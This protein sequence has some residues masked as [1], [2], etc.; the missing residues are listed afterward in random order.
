MTLAILP[1]CLIRL[2][3]HNGFAN[4][5]SFLTHRQA[6]LKGQHDPG[7]IA[8]AVEGLDRKSIPT[9]NGSK[10]ASVAARASRRHPRLILLQTDAEKRIALVR[11]YTSGPPRRAR[12]HSTRRSAAPRSSSA[13]TKPA[14]QNAPMPHKPATKQHAKLRGQYL[15][16]GTSIFVISLSMYLN[17]CAK[18]VCKDVLLTAIVC[19]K[20][21][22]LSKSL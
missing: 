13:W 8:R 7:F 10:S 1:T 11:P 12:R 2:R 15:S 19:I 6:K 4:K 20:N 14:S 22:N 9:D 16:H 3:F 17:V 5:T 21:L 18:I